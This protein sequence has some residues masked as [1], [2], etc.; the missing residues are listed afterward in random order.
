MQPRVIA[1][2]YTLLAELGRGAMG[3]VWHARDKV[4]NRAVAIKELHPQNLGAGEREVLEERMLREARSAGKL[5]HPAVVTVYDIISEDDQ[6]FLAMELVNSLDLA[7]VVERFGPRDPAWVAGVAMQALGALECAHAAGIVHRDV[8]PSNIMVNPDGV[9][10]L[11]D[12]GIAQAVDDPKLTTNGGIVGS[13]AYMS[14]DRLTTGE[15]TPASDLW[16]LGVTMAHAVEGENPF[17]RSTT[18]ATLQA[19]MTGKPKLALASPALAGV[20]NGLLTEDPEARLTAHEARRLLAPIAHGTEVV[21]LPRKGF[22]RVVSAAA[23]AATVA[24]IAAGV[25]AGQGHLFGD[26]DQ[27]H[28]AAP[29]T[30]TQVQVDALVQLWD[31]EQGAGAGVEPPPARRIAT[32]GAGGDIPGFALTGTQCANNLLMQGVPVTQTVPC[33]QPHRIQLFGT[34]TPLWDQPEA[35]YPGTKWLT[36]FAKKYCTDQFQVPVGRASVPLGFTALFPTEQEW[37]ANETSRDV[38]CVVWK[39]DRSPIAGSV[40]G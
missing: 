3:T 33:A 31:G 39:A 13:P 38:L 15:A 21:P 17:E 28:A 8:K 32:F 37:T 25:I 1:D 36:D 27:T 10:K 11:T 4:L 20:I 40:V 30:S 2:R 14:P 34:T 29:T 22:R 23:A 9:V 26:H 24:G 7:T 19:V 5:N 35:P 18:T 16:A 12:F 6:V